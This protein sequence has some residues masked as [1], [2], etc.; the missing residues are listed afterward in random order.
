MI[1]IYPSDDFYDTLEQLQKQTEVQQ[2]QP[3]YWTFKGNAIQGK[4]LYAQMEGYQYRLWRWKS[5][6][7]ICYKRKANNS[8][9]SYLNM[10]SGTGQMQSELEALNLNQ[11]R[12]INSEFHNFKTNS[13]V[14][15]QGPAEITT[16]SFIIDNAY[17]MQFA[18]EG[19]TAAQLLQ[20]PD[21]YAYYD[22]LTPEDQQ[23]LQHLLAFDPQSL[24]HSAWVT[25]ETKRLMLQKLIGFWQHIE[26]EGSIKISDQY[27]QRMVAVREMFNDFHKP[28]TIEQIASFVGLNP[29]KAGALFKQVYGATPYQFFNKK[30]MNEAHYL[31]LN[32]QLQIAEIGVRLGFASMSHFSKAFEKEFGL[33]PKRL[34]LQNL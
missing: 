9:S 33:L 7:G 17:L 16:A 8:N 13:E 3:G 18:P 4:V 5:A 2:V 20:Q 15:I 1:S 29:T 23:V 28:P 27:L 10:A 14:T 32:S 21:S 11:G 19:S 31:V 24:F 6:K 34:Q 26:E 30:R 25:A 12:I 22:V